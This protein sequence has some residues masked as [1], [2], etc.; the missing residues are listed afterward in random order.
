MATTA[1]TTDQ[2]QAAAVKVAEHPVLEA[3]TRAGFIGH[4][5]MHLLLAWLAVQIAFGRPA[6][7]GDQSAALAT[8]VAQP[9]GRLL[10]IA[11]AVGLGAMALWQ[12]LEALVGHRGERGG[13]RTAER[14]LSAGRTVVYAYFAVTAIKI[15]QNAR[16]SSANSQQ[17]LA[18]RLLASGG[19]R[20]VVFLLGAA[21]VIGGA[22]LVW[23][24]ATRHFKKHL[25]FGAATG[26]ARRLVTGI[27]S[28]GYIGKGVAYAIA[29]GL[30]AAAAVTY[31]VDKARGLDSA[32]RTLAGQPYGTFLLLLVAFG[33]ATFGTFAVLQAKYRKV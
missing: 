6:P 9:L 26:P 12:T 18:S 15:V 23:Y 33:L 27:G 32:L 14:L 1:S 29:G 10:V 13:I 30:L 3:L 25:E 5:V 17:A 2:A 28:V 21:V 31:D 20:V 22:G 7:E 8:L 19:G 24:G 4:G 16:A 11:I